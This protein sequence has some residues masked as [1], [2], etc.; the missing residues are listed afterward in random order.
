MRALFAGGGTGGHIMPGA[1]AAEALCDLQPG[2]R[3]L[4]LT[5]NRKAERLCRSSLAEF[6][7]ELIPGLRRTGA[8]DLACLPV[9]MLR[10]GARL[11][12][13]MAR[14]RP[15]VVVGLGE[16]GCAMPVA[17]ARVLGIPTM[18]FEMNAVPGRTVRMLAPM[19]DR[20]VM[21][22]E[23][24]G[25]FLRARRKLPLGSPV[26]RRLF[27]VDR[28]AARRR[29]GLHPDRTTLLAAG[30]SQGALAVNEALH[31]A[32]ELVHR[33]GIDLQVLHI[34]GV[35]HMPAAQDWMES[36][37]YP[38]YRPIGF[39]DRMEDAYAAADFVLGRAGCST[40]AE[41]TALGLPA[42]L[43]PYPHHGDKHQYANAGVLARAGAAVVIPQARLT[44][45]RL[46]GALAELAKDHDCRRRMAACALRM[47]RPGAAG[48]VATELTAMAGFGRPADRTT[49]STEREDNRFSRAA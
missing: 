2:T 36:T 3:C 12:T 30:G 46:A 7:T 37:G 31:P 19:V 4:F 21:A 35:D 24:A 34:T 22:F 44:G 18:L 29:M 11:V 26:R 48:A 47:G 39:L 45:M 32:L 15:H 43:V 1:A 27:G 49:E 41:L 14:F 20:T 9:Q 16:L 38:D 8:V 42:V 17:L 10:S 28:T 40:V 5:T 6:E 33:A 13:V 23:E 25:R